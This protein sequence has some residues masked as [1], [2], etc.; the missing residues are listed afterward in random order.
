MKKL[1]YLLMILAVASCNK[2]NNDPS[3]NPQVLEKQQAPF[4]K[5]SA[6]VFLRKVYYDGHLSREYFYDGN[7]L[8]GQKGYVF[9]KE[10]VLYLTG[11]VR[12]SNGMVDSV[13][14]LSAWVSGEAQTVSKD[15]KP[16]YSMIFD[17]PETDSVRVISR[18]NHISPETYYSK[19]TFDSKGFIVREDL[20]KQYSTMY[21]FVYYYIR[22]DE[23]NVSKSWYT[24]PTETIVPHTITYQYDNH[25][26][27]FFSLGMDRS[28]YISS[29]SLSPNNMVSETITSEGS[30]PRT[31]TY[32]YE[33]MPNGFPGKV[34]ITNEFSEP[35]TLTFEY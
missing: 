16:F 4:G 10:P 25:P 29:A 8:T 5:T 31:I 33:Y 3:P 21:R 14:A 23:N 26:N 35:Y 7:V 1:L 6:D 17:K 20:S 27:P 22:N 13:S 12:R 11:N 34:T 28:D 2:D 18:K 30:A 19:Y 15:F 9:F 32:K 24:S